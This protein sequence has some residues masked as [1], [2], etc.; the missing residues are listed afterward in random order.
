MKKVLVIIV[1][2]AVC[3]FGGWYFFL[4]SSAVA[5]SGYNFVELAR[6]DLES[7]ISA[8]G[9]LSPV[10]TVEIGTQVSGTIDSVFVDYNDQVQKGQVLAVLDTIL[11]RASVLDAEAGVEKAEAQ[12]EQAQ[13]NYERFQP[14]FGKGLISEAEFLPYEIAV[15]TQKATLKSAKASQ[16]RAEQNLGYAV[17]TSPISGTVIKREVETGQ[18][19][20]A[21]LSTPTLFIIA[22][23]MARMEILAE[24][25][26]SDIGLIKT[27]QAV[28]FDVQTYSDK[29][30]EG[31]VTQVRLQPTTISNVVTYTVVVDAA[32][33]DYLL[34]PGMTAT[35]DFIIEDIS[36]A[37]LVP[38]SALRFRPSEEQL[39][40]FRQRRQAERADRPDSLRENRR[41]P[42]GMMGMGGGRNMNRS[43]MGQLWYLD[44]DGN[45]AMGMFKK[46]MTD[47]SNTVIDR[48]RNLT[49]GMQ[50]IGGIG[51]TGTTS[52]SSGS[53][54]SA[55]SGG[56]PRRGPGF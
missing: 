48:S 40:D 56:P 15:K 2:A 17:I 10:T 14:I 13:A 34:L 51:L 55:L 8:S 24:V 27:G 44:D 4:R 37:L 33:D 11:L 18:T 5:E 45:L 19:V 21:S 20:A 23:D 47:G 54:N 12:L 53:G 26:E 31:T 50:V 35:V 9:T 42:E 29:L 39:E 1:I 3:G 36:A 6:G 16:V 22:E 7:T 43:D 46:G 25:D 49:E 41:P 28:R 30:F 32:N 38:N 52:K